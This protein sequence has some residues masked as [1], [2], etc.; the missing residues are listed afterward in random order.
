VS[1]H[2]SGEIVELCARASQEVAAYVQR[3]LGTARM[4]LCRTAEPCAK[5]GGLIEPC[6]SGAGKANLCVHSKWE[7]LATFDGPCACAL[8]HDWSTSQR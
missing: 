2:S 5:H 7:A 3:A 4:R 8:C 6:T 1:S